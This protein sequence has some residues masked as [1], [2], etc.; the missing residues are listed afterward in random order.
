[1]Q[2]NYLTCDGPNCEQ[3]REIINA[4]EATDQGDAGDQPGEDQ[5]DAGQAS[6]GN[7]M[8][9]G[10]DEQAISAWLTLDTGNQIFNFCSFDCL[11]AFVKDPDGSAAS[12]FR[13]YQEFFGYQS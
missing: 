3:R 9:A 10:P 1:M 4:P 2:Y 11:A 7:E 8:A 5:G 13:R 12:A 6:S